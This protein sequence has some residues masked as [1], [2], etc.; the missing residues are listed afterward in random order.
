VG[1]FGVGAA[2]GITTMLRDI[3]TL[4]GTGIFECAKNLSCIFGKDV[5]VLFALSLLNIML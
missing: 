3:A 1:T 2:G 4:N 5:H